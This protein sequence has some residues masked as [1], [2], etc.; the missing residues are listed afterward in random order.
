MKI[1]LCNDTTGYSV[2]IDVRLA[3]EGAPFCELQSLDGFPRLLGGQETVVVDS[4]DQDILYRR[5]KCVLDTAVVP[6]FLPATY[7]IDGTGWV[8]GMIANIGGH[9]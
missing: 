2:W 1:H 6:C 7:R 3:I 9:I 5:S 8:E 4:G